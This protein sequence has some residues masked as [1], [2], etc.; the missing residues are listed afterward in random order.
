M[1]ISQKPMAG[2][3]LARQMPGNRGCT[4]LSAAKRTTRSFV[5]WS[6]GGL[7]LDR[8]GLGD[9]GFRIVTHQSGN[10]RFVIVTANSPSGLKYGCQELIY[11]RMP[12][13]ADQL[14]IDWPM[15]VEMKPQFAYRGIYMLPCWSAYNSLESWKL[16]LKF[17]SELTLNRNWFW[18]NGFPLLEK[19]GGKYKG[20]DLADADN[21]RSLIELCHAEGMKFYI[22]GGWFTWHHIDTALGSKDGKIWHDARNARAEAGGVVTTHHNMQTTTDV[23]VDRGIQYYQDLLALLPAS[24]GLFL[25]PAGEGSDQRKEVA[26]KQQVEALRRLVNGVVAARPA[27][28][29]A[30]AI[31]ANNSPAYRKSLSDIDRKRLYWWWCWGLPVEDKAMDEYPLILGWNL[32]WKSGVPYNRH[33]SRNSPQPHEAGLTGVATTYSSGAGFGNDWNGL[34]KN[35]AAHAGLKEV[36]PHTMSIFLHLYR[37]RERCWNINIDDQQFAARM[38]RRLFDA[39][40]PPESI[41]HYVTL[42]RLVYNPKL[43]TRDVVATIDTFVEQYAGKGTPRNRDTLVWMRE[44]VDQVSKRIPERAAQRPR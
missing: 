28:E 18:L 24:D 9:E 36:H 39:D 23:V 20:S 8:S 17:N 13:R 15:D 7:K 4:S 33:G 40:M 32:L 16:W 6:P 11:F 44:A 5:N 12:A 30:V 34:G 41:G 10:R 19:Y 1:I 14:S 3:S 37:F 29:L 25:E 22:G 43:A 2:P 31:G 21:V 38:A 26:V 27:F 42:N 35:N